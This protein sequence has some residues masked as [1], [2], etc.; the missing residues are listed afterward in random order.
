MP[1]GVGF[2][3]IARVC[4]MMRDSKRK[5][6][7]SM[8]RLICA[9]LVTALVLGLCPGVLAAEDTIKIYTVADLLAMASNPSGNYLLMEDLDMTGVVWMPVDLV[10]GSF[11]GNGHAI[12]NLTVNTPGS[13]TD[14]SYDGNRK[15]YDTCFSGFFGVLRDSEVKNLRLI[16]VRAEVEAD[17]PCFL[18]GIAGAMYDSVLTDCYVSG[19]LELRAFDRMF[20]VGGIAGYGSGTGKRETRYQLVKVHCING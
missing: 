10:G 9:V 18:G 6:G 16:N 19:V 14:I 8:Q 13:T 11:D 1:K 5:E 17:A 2:L 15:E 3:H 12:L 4:G 7:I 20:G